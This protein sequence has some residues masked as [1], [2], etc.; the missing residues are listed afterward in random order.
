MSSNIE[1]KKKCSWCGNA[2][3]ARKTTTEYCCHRCSNLAYKAKK[4]KEK[5]KAFEQEYF[6]KEAQQAEVAH[7]EYLTPSEVAKLLGIDRVTVYRY[8]WSGTLPGVQFKGKTLIRRK[9]IDKLFDEPKPY[10]K[11]QGERASPDYRVLYQRRVA[12]KVRGESVV[13]IQGRQERK[14]S[15][16][17]AARKDAVEQKTFRCR[18]RP[19][20]ARRKHHR[21]VYGRGDAAEIRHD[22]LGGLLLHLYLRHSQE[23]GQ[24]RSLLL[25]AARRC[26]Q[27]AGS[28]DRAGIL[29]LRRGNGAIRSD[30]RPTVSL[31]QMAQD[32][33]S[34]GGT[35]PENFQ[36]RVGC[37]ART[38]GFV[39]PV[40]VIV[41]LSAVI[42]DY[43]RQQPPK[44]VFFAT[45]K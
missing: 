13:D 4:R 30:A 8:M 2:F 35:L 43:N 42:C 36:E 26:S 21:M 11:R 28:S 31:C 25:E 39:A 33:E 22:L 45:R 23:K 40:T 7:L 37:T 34:A 41:R 9:D 18:V 44:T 19:S 3:I 32:S 12:R 15:K 10:Q 14:H 1:I 5:V 17:D 16:S 24:K 29:Y 6:H 38:A 27:R 20:A